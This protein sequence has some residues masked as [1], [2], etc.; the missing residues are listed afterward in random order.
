MPHK[1]SSWLVL[2]ILCALCVFVWFKFSFPNYSLINLQITREQALTIAR[3]YLSTSQRSNPDDFRSA[4]IFLFDD[5]SDRY[6]QKSLGFKKEVAFLKSQDFE[7]YFWLIRF[8]K[9]GKKEEFRFSISAATGEIAAFAHIVD[10]EETRAETTQEQARELA[11]QFLQKRFNINFNDYILAAE[12]QKKL[13]KRVDYS[14]TWQK[15]GVLV[16]WDTKNEFPDSEPGGKGGAAELLMGATVSGQDILSFS[17]NKLDIPEN[18]YR[19]LA[20]HSNLNQT[21]ALVVKIFNVLILVMATMLVVLRRHHVVMYLT[22]P[23]YVSLLLIIMAVI[24]LDNLNDFQVVMYQYVTTSLMENYLSQYLISLLIQTF[25]ISIG[26]ILPCLAAESIRHEQ[27]PEYKT[28]SFLYYLQTGFFNRSVA[29]K[30]MVGYT[31][32]VIMLGLQSVIKEIGLNYFGVWMEHTRRTQF[33]ASYFP[34]F[35]ALA[36]GLQA[37]LFEETTFRMF[38][39][40]LGKKYLKNLA[41]ACVISSLVWA[42]GHSHYQVFPMWFKVMEVAIMGILLSFFYL[43]FGI[44]TV[45]IAHFSF[46]VFWS[47]AGYFIG[48]SNPIYFYPAILVLL[49][50]GFWAVAAYAINRTGEE[51]PLRWRL[52]KHQLF[53]LAVFKCFLKDAQAKNQNLSGLKK[54]ALNHGWDQAVVD[55]ALEETE[56]DKKSDSNSNTSKI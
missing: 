54:E 56:N 28:G 53:H 13:E 18:F 23:F 5:E 51:S 41:L 49:L 20:F 42:G 2:I 47:S 8:F 4:V 36:V 27:L 33:N 26:F 16:E 24:L 52:N 46:N 45:I 55:A 12:L 22:K 3:D 11:S 31:L 34:F 9:E 17:K 25:F 19:Y 14:F 38:G 43:R 44:L 48:H 29:E 32:M 15:K 21:F 7:L 6:L 35:S 40:S 37:S 30:I 39:I 50:P 1:K 10:E